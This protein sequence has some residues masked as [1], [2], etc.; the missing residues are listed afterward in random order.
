MLVSKFGNYGSTEKVLFHFYMDSAITERIK[1][2][3]EDILEFILSLSTDLWKTNTELDS[4]RTLLIFLFL[5]LIKDK[6]LR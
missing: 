1:S 2:I 6:G 5:K 4:V 3:L